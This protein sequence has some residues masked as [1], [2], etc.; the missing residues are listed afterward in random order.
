VEKSS[1]H[2]KLGVE[3]LAENKTAVETQTILWQ[4]QNKNHHTKRKTIPYLK[5]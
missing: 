4:P 1:L 5:V 3:K 2:T